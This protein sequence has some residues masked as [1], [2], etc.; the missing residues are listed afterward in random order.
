MPISL[1]PLYL[2]RLFNSLAD[3]NLL[4]NDSSNCMGRVA[5]P[6]IVHFMEHFE[7][8]FSSYKSISC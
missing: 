8:I 5:G 3:L 4:L 1:K 7:G 2:L 6:I